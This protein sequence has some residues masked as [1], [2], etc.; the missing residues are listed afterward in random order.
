MHCETSHHFDHRPGG[1][2][3]SQE[4]GTHKENNCLRVDRGTAQFGSDARRWRESV[5]RRKMGRRI[6]GCLG[7]SRRFAHET[8]QK[9]IQPSLSDFF[10]CGFCWIQTYCWILPF[11]AGSFFRKALWLF[12]GQRNS[13]DRVQLPG[14]RYRERIYCT[15]GRLE[16]EIIRN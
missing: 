15:L 1:T 8:S 5:L 3:Q 10:G 2:P 13:R 16:E 9:K 12:S 4:T 6:P 7:F 11:G 14:I